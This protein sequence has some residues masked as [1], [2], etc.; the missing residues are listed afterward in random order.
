MK[1]SFI[2][3]ILTFLIIHSFAQIIKPD[4]SFNQNGKNILS[5]NTK[6]DIG[7]D[8]KVLF[9]KNLLTSSLKYN[10]P[11]NGLSQYFEIFIFNKNY[12][13]LSFNNFGNGTGQISFNTFAQSAGG[14]NP[15]IKILENGFFVTYMGG[16]TNADYYDLVTTKFK[17]NGDVDSSF[18]N[19]GRFTFKSSSINFEYISFIKSSIDSSGNIYFS[20][21][22]TQDEF[23][24]VNEIIVVKISKDGKIDSTFSGDGVEKYP[25]PAAFSNYVGQ[26]IT[27]VNDNQIVIAGYSGG[28]FSSTNTILL[29]LDST[30]GFDYNFDGNGYKILSTNTKMSEMMLDSTGRLIVVGL[31]GGTSTEDVFAAAV[32]PDGRLDSTF[33]INGKASFN[34]LGLNEAAI[35]MAITPEN[36]ILIGG[37]VNDPV[38]NPITKRDFLVM[39]LNS[40]GSLDSTFNQIGYYITEFTAGSNRDD[41]MNGI[42]IDGKR[43]YLTGTET[44]SHQVNFRAVVMCLRDNMATGLIEQINQNLGIKYYPNPTDGNF[45]IEIPDRVIGINYIVLDQLGR[46]VQSGELNQSRTMIDLQDLANGMYIVRVGDE[47]KNS[48]KVVKQ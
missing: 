23:S 25:Y 15:I 38:N 29:S 30:G 39:R 47:G 1:A 40:D 46:R 44:I 45:T 7:Y 27:V 19:N 36:K 48:F 2:F 42:T 18:G 24:L 4:S 3:T 43:I 22:F 14:I 21:T 26:G 35:C 31:T 20:A 5:L 34:L 32:F 33:G 12:N 37:Y 41:E 28:F 8:T 13:G 17:F 6:I 11:I 10:P 9:N 16:I